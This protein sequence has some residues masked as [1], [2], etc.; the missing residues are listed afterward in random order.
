ME[1]LS[2]P[3]IRKNLTSLTFIETASINLST[4]DDRG[5]LIRHD[6]QMLSDNA[7]VI[8][9]MSDDKF[10][11][12]AIVSPAVGSYFQAKTMLN[13]EYLQNTL[14]LSSLW[15]SPDTDTNEILPGILYLAL[16]RGRIWNKT[17]IVS[18][19]PNV[20]ALLASTAKLQVLSNLSVIENQGVILYPVAQ[21]IKYSLYYLYQSTKGTYRDI[22]NQNIVHEIVETVNKWLFNNVFKSPWV[23]AIFDGSFTKQQYIHL[24]YNTYQYVRLTLRLISRC[25]AFSDNMELRDHFVYHLRGEVNHELII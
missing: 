11:A 1:T 22:I 14:F 7:M 4:L 9:L 6:H 12:V 10:K 19:L 17:N 24:L 13:S 20:N 23:Q 15:L 8:S 3:R 5:W 2:E 25:I 16:R 18:L 21:R